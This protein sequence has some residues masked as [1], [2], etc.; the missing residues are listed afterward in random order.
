MIIV[1]SI[2]EW[3]DILKTIDNNKSIGFVPTLGGLHEGHISLF[4]KCR[5]NNNVA[6]ASI[7]LNPTQFN[8]P[9]DLNSYPSILEDDLKEAEKAGIDY[10]FLPTKEQIYPD[11]YAF[12]V[13]ENNFSTSMEGAHRPGHFDGV[14]TVV[15]KLLNIIKPN[16]LYLGEKDYQQAKLIENMV[17]SFF[18][19]IHI[20]ICP[21]VRDQ[22]G[23]ALSSRNRKL[24][25]HQQVVAA[26]FSRSLKSTVSDKQLIQDLNQKGFIV[27]YIETH[28]NRRFGAINFNGV[29][30]IDNRPLSNL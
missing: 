22:N 26:E 3:R 8:N 27:E 17:N 16:V 7:F 9:E 1:K 12:Q 4:K 2:Q 20:E 6:V 11:D 28:K 15:M 10:L 18:M 23:L 5:A 29:R 24:T 21:T 13:T 14:L 25:K 19:E 30:L